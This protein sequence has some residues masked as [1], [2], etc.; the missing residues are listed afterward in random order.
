MAYGCFWDAWGTKEMQVVAIGNV[1][2]E[3]KLLSLETGSLVRV[4]LRIMQDAGRC[5]K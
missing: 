1:S 4:S 3:G 2:D 5:V